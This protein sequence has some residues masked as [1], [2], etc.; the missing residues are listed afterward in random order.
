[1]SKNA[2]VFNEFEE[3][4][5]N[6][7]YVLIARRVQASDESV[8]LNWKHFTIMAYIKEQESV[9]PSLISDALQMSRS[10]ISK[11]LK[12][13]AD[14]NLITLLPAGQDR[15]SHQVMLSAE[16]NT[17]LDNIYKGQHHNAKMASQSLTA[18]EMRQ[19]CTIARKITAA[20]DD[21]SLRTV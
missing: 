9:S 5:T 7:Q 16:A 1:M 14:K 6:L 3:T 12:S 11:Y 2:Q 4:L 10:S 21:E 15:R 8:R 13:L 18:E 17:I 19:F 20:L